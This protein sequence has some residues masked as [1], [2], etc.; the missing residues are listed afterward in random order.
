MWAYRCYVTS[1]R[2]NLWAAWYAEQ[3]DEVRAKHDSTF[4]FLEAR[5][6]W[7]KPHYHP[8]K[9]KI[10][11]GEVT[12]KGKVAWRIFGFRRT[13]DGVREFVVTDIGY[14]KDKVYSPHGLIARAQRRAE[15]IE[16]DLSK[17]KPCERPQ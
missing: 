16:N 13:T 4:S 6:E 3:S 5:V 11:L 15:E 8:L 12:L 14:H 2:P 10:R 7:G 1:E 17:S 9:G